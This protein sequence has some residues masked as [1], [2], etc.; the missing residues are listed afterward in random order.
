M[1]MDFENLDILELMEVLG[2]M[3][4]VGNGSA[5]IVSPILDI[6]GINGVATLRFYRKQTSMMIPQILSVYYRTSASGQWTLIQQ[7]TNTTDWTEETLT[8]PNPSAT[9]QI[10]FLGFFNAESASD[11]IDI[12]SLMM[13]GDNMDF[14]SDIYL[15]DIYVGSGTGSPCPAPQNLTVSYINANGATINWDGA[16]TNYT[17]EY[18]PVGFSHGNGTTVTAPNPVYTFT[19]LA[20]NTTYDVYVRSNCSGGLTSDWTQTNF[21]TANGNGIGENGLT[22]LTLSPN[23][24]TGIVR[25]SINSEISNARLQVLDVYGKLLMEQT[26]T[27][28]T[29]ELNFSDKAAGIYFLRVIDGNKVLTTQKVVRR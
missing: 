24:T 19:G 29:A 22:F 9:Y 12:M 2:D 14:S 23:P 1:N 27:E 3:Q 5:R 11:D 26:V 17:I 15:D 21:T 8:L 18:G 25:C 10:A 28:A 6:T 7:Y 20:P 4:N 13:G 16:A